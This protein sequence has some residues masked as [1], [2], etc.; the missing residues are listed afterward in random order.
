MIAKALRS[1]RPDAEWTLVGEDLSGLVWLSD[2]QPPTAEEVNHEI[3]RL[4]PI[5]ECLEN[6]RASYP[7]IVDQLDM[8]YHDIDGWK[9]TIKAIKEQFPKPEV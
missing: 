2:G 4:K 8:I 3:A 7:S 1:L 5:L 6:R 9:S